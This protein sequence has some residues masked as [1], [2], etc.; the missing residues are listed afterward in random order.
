MTIF[1]INIFWLHIAPSYYWLMYALWFALWYYIVKKRW[2]IKWDLLDDLLFYIFLWVIWGWRLWYVLFYNFNYYINNIIDI[3][4]VWEWWMSFHGWVIGVII[5]MIL[6]SR[7]NNISFYRVADE[8]TAILPIWIW[9]GRIWNYLNKELLWFSPYN[10]L[11]AIQKN[12]INYFPSPLLEALLEWL[13]LY[14]IL[15]YYYKRKRSNWQLAS[16]FL[17][18]YWIFRLIVEIFFRTPDSHIWYILIYF[19]M[20]E[21]LTIPMI[22]FW[23]YFYFKL[24]NKKN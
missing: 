24:D 15:Y 18:I 19:T 17:I 5:A 23:L 16:L 6:F 21:L 3:L 22:L 10:W 14:I 20:W 4:K 9:L 12:N 11:L 1:D 8:V 13:V 2:I 7:K